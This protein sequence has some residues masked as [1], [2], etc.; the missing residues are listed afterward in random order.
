MDIK[1]IYPRKLRKLWAELTK[2]EGYLIP[3]TIED[4]KELGFFEFFKHNNYHVYAKPETLKIW[5]DFGEAVKAFIGGDLY[6]T[7]TINKASKEQLTAYLTGQDVNNFESQMSKIISTILAECKKRRY[8]QSISGL[9]VNSSFDIQVGNWRLT[10]FSEDNI[11]DIIKSMSCEDSWK[12]IVTEHLTKEFLGKCCLIVEAI[13]D[14]EQA[15]IAADQVMRFIVNTLRYAICVRFAES[16]LAHRLRIELS[17]NSSK[18]ST[19]Y[20]CYEAETGTA[21]INRGSSSF[22]QSYELS[23]EEVD[24]LIVDWHFNEL[25]SLY[26]KFDLTDV[27][28]A[29]IEAITWIGEAQSDSDSHI[30]FIKYWTA[31]EALVT[32]Y[33]CGKETDRLKISIPILLNQLKCDVPSKNKVDKMYARRSNM[34]HGRNKPIVSS[35]ELNQV[36]Q[37]A[38][39]AVTVYLDLR[40]KGYTT[41]R[42]IY[43]QTKRI[44]DIKKHKQLET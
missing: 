21:L 3:E 20:F 29:I 41:R 5:Y 27:E 30:S 15:R 4:F 23:R 11:N 10:S 36:C 33:E 44:D 42:Q 25:W 16:G 31:L 24:A 37:W 13:G 43:E 2:H 38:Y 40:G 14:H 19:N 7:T 9:E 28:L 8:I 22:R 6:S 32:G 26:Y 18:Y 35:S 12:T 34:L 39:R 1:S 17:A